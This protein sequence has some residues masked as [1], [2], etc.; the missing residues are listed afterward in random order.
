MDLSKT[1][2]PVMS[3]R[4]QNKNFHYSSSYRNIILTTTHGEEYL[5]STF[6]RAQKSSRGV[7]VPY[8]SRKSENK[9][10]EE[11]K[12][13]SFTL[14]TSPALQSGTAQC[15]ERPHQ[16]MISLLGLY[17]S[18]VNAWLPQLA[19]CFPR[20]PLFSCTNQNTKG[21]SMAK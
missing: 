5:W 8:Q 1:Y 9:C 11:G 21:I 16:P 19:R 7:P 18:T 4:Q 6:M 17:E 12:R 14:F 3:A 10:N 15:Q 2:K 13:S 20:G